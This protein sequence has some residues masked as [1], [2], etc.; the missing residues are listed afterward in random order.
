MVINGNK[1]KT[2]NKKPEVDLTMDEKLGVELDVKLAIKTICK[3][4]HKKVFKVK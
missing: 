3:Q 1:S 2:L 4:W